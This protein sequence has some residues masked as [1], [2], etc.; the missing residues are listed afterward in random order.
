M[1]QLQTCNGQAQ[2][3]QLL[4]PTILGSITVQPTL[5]PS[6]ESQARVTKPSENHTPCA[7]YKTCKSFSLYRCGI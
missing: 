3:S 6:L 7:T 1:T 4:D 5:M 2:I